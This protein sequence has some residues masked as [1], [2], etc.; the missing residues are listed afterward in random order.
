MLSTR[1]ERIR[2]LVEEGHSYRVISIML[3][4]STSVVCR[5]FR[6]FREAISKFNNYTSPEER[7]RITAALEGMSTR[8]EGER[9]LRSIAREFGRS[10]YTI[11]RVRNA[12]Y[13]DGL[14][15]EPNAVQFQRTKRKHV[16]PI[17]RAA[18]VV[19]PCPACAAQAQLDQIRRDRNANSPTF[20]PPPPNER[21]S[22]AANNGSPPRLRSSVAS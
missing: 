1:T 12:A 10:A 16:C 21:R 20:G 19:R 3:G 15:D 22:T 5:S 4:I 17:C 9:S 6:P 13:G 18:I 2:R 7:Q 11:I 8:P 14:C